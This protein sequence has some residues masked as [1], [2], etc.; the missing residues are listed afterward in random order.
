MIYNYYKY[1]YIILMIFNLNDLILTEGDYNDFLNLYNQLSII[2]SEDFS[3]VDFKDFITSLYNNPNHNIYV[4]M[5]DNK[6]VGTITLLLEQ[7]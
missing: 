4:Y 7:N 6:I 2:N 3:Y 1:L 5:I